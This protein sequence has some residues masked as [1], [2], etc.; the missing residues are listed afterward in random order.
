MAEN[1]HV[2]PR[3]LRAYES[4]QETVYAGAR[5]SLEKGKSILAQP[6][7]IATLETGETI[8][9][10][11][12]WTTMGLWLKAP[13]PGNSDWSRLKKRCEDE[14]LRI[15]SLTLLVPG[16]G[17]FPAPAG[18]GAYGF[19][20]QWEAEAL[21]G[22]MGCKGLGICWPEK[23]GSQQVVKVLLIKAGGVLEEWLRPKWQPCMIGEPEME[24]GKTGKGDEVNG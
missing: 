23:L 22:K 4:G 11:P 21:S 14:K 7:W 24:T 19:F 6:T 8:I 16:F 12:S 10:K 3:Q 18:K 20:E 13:D 5:G 1:P 15:K 2:H 17:V 9:G